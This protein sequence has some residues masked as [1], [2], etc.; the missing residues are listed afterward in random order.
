MQAILVEIK[1]WYDFRITCFVINLCPIIL[2]TNWTTSSELKIKTFCKPFGMPH[3]HLILLFCYM[4][5]ALEAGVKMSFATS[6]G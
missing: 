5:A 4:Y 2:S 6:T 1:L 3:I